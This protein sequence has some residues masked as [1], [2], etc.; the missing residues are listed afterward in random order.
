MSLSLAMSTPQKNVYALQAVEPNIL[1]C[2]EPLVLESGDVLHDVRIA[3]HTW[4]TL[5]AN[6]SNVVW[7]CHALTGNSNAADWW[8]GL[9]GAGRYLDPDEYFI[10]CANIIGSCYGSTSPLSVN[11]NAKVPYY[12]HFPTVTIRDVV[13]G[14]IALRKHLGIESIHLLVGGS[15]GG[16][17]VLEWAIIEP[18]IPQNIAIL[19]AGA[20]ISPWAVGLNAT[21]RMA[22]EADATWGMPLATA[23]Q[24]GLATA[25]AVGMLSYRSYESFAERQSDADHVLDQRRADTYLRYQGEKLVRRFDAYSYYTLT[26]I[27][28]THN[29]GRG[30]GGVANALAQI[31]ANAIVVG[32]SS[33]ILFPPSEQE[34]LVETLPRATLHI[35]DSIY[36][37]D[38]FLIEFEQLSC[39]FNEC[40]QAPQLL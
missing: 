14:H 30:R 12:Q 32:V 5:N 38:G 28:D 6:Q 39:I 40:L 21:Q 8:N 17:Q 3:Y 36:G 1:H 16:Q 11:P 23:A 10:I 4:G 34:T 24:H 25:R 9:V 15:M 35:I 37:H 7:I 13:Q 26:K 19:A 18:H 27:M 2:T 22:I 33:D 31:Q 20:A 29:V